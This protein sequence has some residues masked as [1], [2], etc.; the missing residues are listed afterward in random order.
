MTGYFF[1]NSTASGKP[2]YPNPMI[3]SFFSAS[4]TNFFAKIRREQGLVREVKKEETSCGA[5]D[6]CDE[7]ASTNARGECLRLA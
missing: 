2:T 7:C 3:A 1:E 6:V 5:T 4:I